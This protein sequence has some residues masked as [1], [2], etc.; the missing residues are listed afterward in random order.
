MVIGAFE[1]IFV[2]GPIIPSVRR[3]NPETS[4]WR[5]ARMMQRG[6]LIGYVDEPSLEE[7]TLRFIDMFGDA[8]DEFPKV[9]E[10]LFEPFQTTA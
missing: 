3:E 4:L 7:R 6:V 8:C 2:E 9:A 5:L 1:P 10:L